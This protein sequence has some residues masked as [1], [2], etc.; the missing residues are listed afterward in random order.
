MLTLSANHFMLSQRD[1]KELL[2]SY[3]HQ[4]PDETDRVKVFI[5]FLDNTPSGQL[6]AR[7]NFNGH[8]TTSAFI[9]KPDSREMLLLKHKS[10][11]RWLQPGGHVE[12]DASLL[13]SA[14]REA[15]EETGVRRSQLLHIH[16]GDAGH[17]PFDIDPHFIPP[18]PKKAEDGHYHHDHRYLFIYQ[19]D[20]K[21]DFDP[22]ESTGLKWVRF[23]DLT[24]D[25]TFG[26]MVRKIDI[27]LANINK[28][29]L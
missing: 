9:V 28:S 18:N 19:G 20:D 29:R 7:K 15:N 5:D 25:T 11:G 24:G 12:E 26:E 17:V 8:I 2:C 16:V 6:F 10:L 14:L 3:L 13:D 27:A 4:F 23:D 22:D 21:E 1:I